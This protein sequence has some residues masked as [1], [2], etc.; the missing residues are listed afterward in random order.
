VLE[1]YKEVNLFL[2]ND[3]AGR[4]CRDTIVAHLCKEAPS[5]N[6]C[7]LSAVYGK[8]KDLN[9]MLCNESTTGL[10]SK[11]TAYGHKIIK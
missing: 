4:K 11:N 8:H 3:Q 10:P 2:D 9:S 1:N 5:I 6:V 7:D